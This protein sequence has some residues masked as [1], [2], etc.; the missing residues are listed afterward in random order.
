[1]TNV[2]EKEPATET[3]LLHSGKESPPYK[4]YG[5]VLA[6]IVAVR[7]LD[8]ATQNMSWAFTIY[9]SNACWF[10]FG[11]AAFFIGVFAPSSLCKR[12]SKIMAVLIAGLLGGSLCIFT[13]STIGIVCGVLG[14]LLA[15]LDE[16][17]RRAGQYALWTF[18]PILLVGFL[19]G[20]AAAFSLINLPDRTISL[21]LFATVGPLIIGVIVLIMLLW[22]IDANR[23][24]YTWP[25]N[26]L[27]F[28]VTVIVSFVFSVNLDLYRRDQ[29]MVN[30][31]SRPT[32]SEWLSP[33]FSTQTTQAA[34]QMVEE[35]LNHFHRGHL[36]FQKDSDSTDIAYARGFPRLLALSVMAG[37]KITDD[38]LRVLDLRYLTNLSCE[39]GTRLTGK[40]LGDLDLSN[41]QYLL[42]AGPNFGDDALRGLR[43]AKRMWYLSLRNTRVTS[44]GIQ[45][46]NRRIGIYY[47]DLTNTLVDDDAVTAIS[48]FP[49][50]QGIEL[51]GT[52]VTGK[53]LGSL[54][55]RA[56]QTLK[57]SDTPLDEKYLADLL[58]PDGKKGT[59]LNQARI[60]TL[61]LAN[62]PL[63]ENALRTVSQI[64]SL[65]HV[66]IS[67]SK[68]SQDAISRLDGLSSLQTLTLDAKHFVEQGLSVRPHINLYLVYRNDTPLSEIEEHA[69]PILQ[70]RDR[71]TSTGITLDGIT[72]TE[73]ST[74]KIIQL[75][76]TFE[77]SVQLTNAILPDGTKRSFYNPYLL[78]T[79]A[80]DQFGIDATTLSD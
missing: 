80:K 66:N 19:T 77:N 79:F 65:T 23:R 69:K 5:G 9:S 32:R 67:G 36:T 50:I 72:L 11:A 71:S 1:M 51:G 26:L 76:D 17:R 31:R 73:E 28:A 21:E 55:G 48:K 58:P 59:E 52:N 68:P 12:T 29:A 63:T 2:T 39:Y 6:L 43:R 33:Y 14:S 16:S 20:A 42:I 62:V 45:M 53:T 15:V 13:S 3:S 10:L 7:I 46:L 30:L 40:S 35:N 70:T 49:N 64:S 57:L 4:L 74:R 22:R 18:M 54:R 60:S 27:L 41:V 44:A 8:L 38:D 24:F 34:A 75:M 78:E 47:V 37:S 61:E 56:L 25:F